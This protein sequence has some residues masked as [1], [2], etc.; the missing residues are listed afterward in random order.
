MLLVSLVLV[1]VLMGVV[2]YLLPFKFG[3]AIVFSVQAYLGLALYFLFSRNIEQGTFHAILGGEDPILYVALR[4]D[5]LSLIFVGLSII[6]FTLA[7]TYASRFESYCNKKFLFFFIMLQGV[8]QGIFLTD[9]I[10]NLFVLIE[11]STVIATV[12]LLFRRDGRNAYDGL[13]YIT[14]QI[15]TM[16]FFLFGVAYLYRAFGVLNFTA[17]AQIMTQGVPSEALVLPFSFLMTGIALKIGF[18]PLFSWISHAYGNSSA[19]FPVLAILSGLF[20]KSSLFFVIRIHNLFYPT[21][22][23][24]LFFI[25]LGLITGVIGAVKALSQKDIRL[26]L[27]FSTVSQVGLIT[28][29]IF[30]AL[31]TSYYGALMHIINHA[32]FKSLLFLSAGMIARVYQTTN[33]D[34]INSLFKRMPITSLATLVGILGI[35]GF[36]FINGSISKYWIM[37]DV[38]FG[39]ELALW[40]L[41]AGTMLVFIKYSTMFFGRNGDKA[42]VDPLKNTAVL[43]LAAM[44]I[45]AGVF[46]VPLTNFLFDVN[47]TIS[48]GPF[49]A[50]G[51][52][53]FA[54][55]CGMII[56]YRATLA[57]SDFLFKFAKSKSTVQQ[58]CFVLL[59]FFA[60]L[61]LYGMVG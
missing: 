7:F 18:F 48:M 40:V 49:L 16:M 25:S 46:G 55:L 21:L 50:K 6:L 37:A 14:M 42:N 22:D 34:E 44:C 31:N 27:A 54:V 26:M 20:V 36:P 39:L 24:T 11:V 17:M 28:V 19:P 4:G 2:L 58:S 53:F 38:S 9:D 41:N 13:F 60:S 56:L 12:L 35:I 5:R 59:I 32:L 23:Y 30:S 45:A 47:L 8:M 61:V 29:G 52:I 33:V 1:P 57:K 51:A 43:V 15:V 10:F 3:K